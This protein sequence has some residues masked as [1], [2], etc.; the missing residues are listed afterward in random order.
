[1]TKLRYPY[2]YHSSAPPKWPTMTVSVE[3]PTDEVIHENVTENR[4][5]EEEDFSHLYSLKSLNDVLST[6]EV[7]HIG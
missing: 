5:E 1:M 4:E 3:A 2:S 7:Y 6:D